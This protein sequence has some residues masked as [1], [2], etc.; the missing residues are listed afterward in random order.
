MRLADYAT[1]ASPMGPSGGPCGP[2][3][4]GNHPKHKLSRATVF[5]KKTLEDHVM[6]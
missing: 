1:F 6:Q 2:S 4:P 5:E 3:M